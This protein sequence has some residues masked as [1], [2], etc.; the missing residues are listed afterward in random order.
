M[1]LTLF[2]KNL[3]LLRFDVRQVKKE[4]IVAH[5]RHPVWHLHLFPFSSTLLNLHNSSV[6]RSF[7]FVI[8]TLDGIIRF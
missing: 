1:I 8:T 4:C 7:P 6:T 2:V 5:D 3:F